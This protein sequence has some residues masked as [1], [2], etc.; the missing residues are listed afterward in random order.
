MLLLLVVNW[1]M[2]LNKCGTFELTFFLNENI[3]F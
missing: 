2:R 1:V 3:F